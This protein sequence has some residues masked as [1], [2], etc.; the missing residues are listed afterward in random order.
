MR[1]DIAV[2]GRDDSFTGFEEPAIITGVSVDGSDRA[3]TKGSVSANGSSST[4][5]CSYRTCGMLVTR[6]LSTV[7][8]ETTKVPPLRL[9]LGI[10]VVKT[11]VCFDWEERVSCEYSIST[12]WEESK[13]NP[14]TNLGSSSSRQ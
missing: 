14:E 7:P 8:S 3:S 4:S 12:L 11:Q 5:S 6:Q 9:R 1:F 13:Y 2:E 10:A